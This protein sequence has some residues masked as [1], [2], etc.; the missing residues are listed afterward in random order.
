MIK[1]WIAFLAGT[2]V[3][4]A[5]GYLFIEVIDLSR[6]NLFMASAMTGMVALSVAIIIRQ[7]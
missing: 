1:R 7:L 6:P 5:G 2:L 4:T 3:L